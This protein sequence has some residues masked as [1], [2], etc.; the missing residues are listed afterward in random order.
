[1]KK[2]MALILALAMVM[3]PLASCA[4]K[5]DD[6]GGGGGGEAE[7]TDAAT[8]GA[9]TQAETESADVFDVPKGFA[10]GVD[11]MFLVPEIVHYNFTQ[12]DFDE[13]AEDMYSNA[14]YQ[15][16]IAVEDYLGCTINETDGGAY[17]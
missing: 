6:G 12:I 1:M 3:I 7:S 14:I 9:E 8:G 10:E 4:D 13:P 2:Y 11:F 15:R 5:T 16:N 17:T